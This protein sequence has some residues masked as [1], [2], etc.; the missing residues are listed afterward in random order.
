MPVARSSPTDGY[1]SRGTPTAPPQR[2]VIFA[3]EVREQGP[4]GLFQR[5]EHAPVLVERGLDS[6]AEVVGRAAAAE[7]EAVVR[8]ALAVDDQEPR[9]GE[10]LAFA[11]PCRR[12]ESGGQRFGR[13]HERVDGRDRTLQSGQ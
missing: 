6:R 8:G 9:V 1:Q 13:D 5:V 12:P 2:W 4:Q 3:R 7:R 11:K 10:G